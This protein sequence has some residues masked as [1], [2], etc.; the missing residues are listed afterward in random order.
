MM[1]N[2][3]RR[4]VVHLCLTLMIT[5][6]IPLDYI[7]ERLINSA[8]AA[9]ETTKEYDLNYGG[10]AQAGY[11]GYYS[12]QATLQGD[13]RPIADIQGISGMKIKQVELIRDNQPAGTLTT[14]IG[15][16]SWW[17][18]VDV[19]S[20]IIDVASEENDKTP[21]Y[22]AWYR[23]SQSSPEKRWYANEGKPT[24]PKLCGSATKDEY[25]MPKVPGCS[26]IVT[27]NVSRTQPYKTVVGDTE[28]SSTVVEVTGFSTPN[29]RK[30]IDVN[31]PEGTKGISEGTSGP[32]RIYN[33]RLKKNGDSTESFTIEYEQ[34]FMAYPTSEPG[35][36]PA[37]KNLAASGAKLMVYFGSF[38]FDIYGKTYKYPN[39]VRVTYEPEVN[40][41]PNLGGISVVE[42]VCVPRGV[43]QSYSFSFTNDG[44]TDVTTPFKTEVRIDGSV[45]RTFNY[46]GLAVGAKKTESFSHTIYSDQSVTISIDKL[47]SE[48]NHADNVM[49]F[50]VKPQATCEP[51]GG[52][53]N[54]PPGPEVITGTLEVEKP[55]VK[56]GELNYTWLRNVTVSG[57]NSC[58]LAT[59]TIIYSQSG[60]SKSY[61]LDKSGT[62]SSQF[63]A[64][65]Y[66]GVSTGQVTVQYDITTTCGSKKTFGPGSF[67]VVSDPDNHPPE[68]EPSWFYSYYYNGYADK[69][70]VVTVGEMVS[71]GPVTR[72]KIEALGDNGTPYDPDGDTIQYYWDFAGSS[73]SWI[74][75]LGD[76]REGR[77][78]YPY[79]TSFNGIRATELGTHTIMVTAFDGRGGTSG[80]KSVTLVV[81]EE[82]PDPII[83]LPPKV[84]E[85]RP[86]TPDISCANSQSPHRDRWIASCDWHGTKLPLYPTAGDYPIKLD[87][88]DN[89]GLRSKEPAHAIL[90]VLPDLPPDILLEQPNYG[91]RNKELSFRDLSKSPDGD[92]IKKHTITLAY[93][94]NNNGS[95]DDET[96][97][98]MPLNAQ[99]YFKYTATQV[100]KYRIRIYMEEATPMA[101][102][103]Q[104][105]F[106]FEIVNDAPEASFYIE[107]DNYKPPKIETKQISSA[108]LLGAAW[109]S[110]STYQMSEMKGYVYNQAENAIETP[111][112]N[113]SQ[114][115]AVTG[116]DF[117]KIG[118]YWY[119][120]NCVNP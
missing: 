106:I 117:K 35:P 22:F 93:D 111:T 47:P 62:F 69:A 4:I 104:K 19:N 15:Y 28:I 92:P 44:T 105:D 86:Y 76:E 25:N 97:L 107:G 14:P 63:V 112:P 64:S 75:W 108:D 20:L 6:L 114:Y 54:P 113:Y 26:A 1:N 94:S 55:T 120:N 84:V 48:T 59:G 100:G 30:D 5:G 45:I 96:P 98:S 119:C 65:P 72:P 79:D 118:K 70:Q 110:S 99:G 68:F 81:R 77:G 90:N 16:G 31:G 37:I 13:A 8:Q 39:R 71:L 91:I 46:S 51:G 66:N 82:N 41:K 34:D 32:N 61:K 2:V 102:W 60:H 29:V 67:V 40:P 57:G 73:S 53:G 87:V 10:V 33:P 103:A 58:S 85:G 23:Y 95:Y 116:D 49:T 109:K 42:K 78:L 88:T 11:Q 27:F 3:L 18:P 83:T 89:T 12:A 101:K 36:N 74:R 7:V 24:D 50:H 17:G 56:Y 52:G 21:T 115:R 38:D 9:G 80:P 43:S